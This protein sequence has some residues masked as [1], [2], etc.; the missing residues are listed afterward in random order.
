MEE[1][2]LSRE[3]LLKE[4]SRLNSVLKYYSDKYLELETA[5]RKLKI[6]RAEAKGIYD[7]EINLYG[8]L[9]ET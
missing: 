5:V 1:K 6:A 3:E 7:A 9:E 8:L 4:N 2:N